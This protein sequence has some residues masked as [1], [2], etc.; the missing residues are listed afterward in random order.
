M[1]LWFMS[2]QFL[3]CLRY[4]QRI[5]ENIE[6]QSYKTISSFVD[7]YIRGCFMLL[8]NVTCKLNI[9]S[10]ALIFFFVMNRITFPKSDRPLN[11]VPVVL[12]MCQLSALENRNT[13]RLFQC[14]IRKSLK[15]VIHYQSGNRK[16]FFFHFH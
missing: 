1:I 12:S 14:G 4:T 6:I 7:F 5:K 16:Y 15:S 9:K 2:K 10:I 11:S 8:P 13:Q 3:I